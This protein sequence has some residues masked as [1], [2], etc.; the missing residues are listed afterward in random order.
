MSRI[1]F[2][3]GRLS[4]MVGDRIQAFPWPHWREEFPA[5]R[6]LGF[7]LMEWTVDRERLPENPIMTRAGR[8]EVRS[9]TDAF[10]VRVRSLTADCV[11][12]APF[13]KAADGERA[14]RL[15]DLQALIDACA[16]IGIVLLVIPLVDNGRL[17]NDPQEEDLRRG[18]LPL[19]P[20]LRDAGMRA[21]FESD[22]PPRR[23]REFI[24][25][26]PQDVFGVNY[27]TGNSAA[28]GYDPHEEIEGYGERIW[29]VHVKDRR[30]GGTTVPLGTG[31]ADLPTAFRLLARLGYA[32]GYILQTARA[33][34]GD[35][36]AALRRYR[37]MAASWL[38][39][40][41][42]S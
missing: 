40:A 19:A 14:R 6:S 32:G 39:A 28:L 42:G 4:P 17:E 41:D 1:G 33:A 20:V 3:Q 27:D 34:D 29:N 8:Q 25:T 38:A 18:L 24:G 36:A 30:R 10:G 21:V 2:M 7:T 12:E 13:Y 31:E 26:F 23:L 9:L 5:A 15:D 22:F 35:H 16:Q 37:D 11:M